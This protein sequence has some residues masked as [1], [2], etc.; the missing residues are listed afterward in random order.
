LETKKTDSSEKDKP[1]PM[2]TQSNSSSNSS[3]SN[4][5]SKPAVS[6]FQIFV[7]TLTGKTV[8]VDC[9]PFTT[10][11]EFKSKLGKMEGIPEDQQRL[12]F[13]GK[14]LEDGRTLADYK[15]Q[16][17]STL[18]L[19]L[20]LRGGMYHSTSGRQDL[21]HLLKLENEDKMLAAV[22]RKST[23]ELEQLM[24]KIQSE[25]GKRASKLKKS[26]A[27]KAAKQSKAK[28]SSSDAQ[29]PQQKGTKRKEIV[30][31]LISD[32]EEEE[33]ELPKKEESDSDE[34]EIVEPEEEDSKPKRKRQK[35]KK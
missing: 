1:V 8:T 5:S 11:Q 14:Q 21:E 31:S 12:I 29:E 23:A 20:R 25:L 32:D 16:K 13:A 9:D 15:I 4:N 7:K 10:L 6:Q 26:V 18:H 3:N 34:V 27:K 30:I 24:Q 35:L 22:Q 28:D 17:E 2:D 33:E 19:V